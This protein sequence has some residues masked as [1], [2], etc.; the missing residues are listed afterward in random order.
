MAAS[1]LNTP[2]GIEASILVVRAFVK[3]RELLATHKQLARKFRELEKHIKDHDG[4]IEVIFKAI[5]QLMAP[6]E[7][8]KR[9]HAVK[10]RFPA[11]SSRAIWR[12]AGAAC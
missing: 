5:R 3:L 2:R 7:K 6:P 10:R 12:R 8:P 1:V 11:C 9:I 4:K